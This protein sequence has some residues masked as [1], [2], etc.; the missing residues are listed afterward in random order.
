[1]NRLWPWVMFLRLKFVLNASRDGMIVRNQV[2]GNTI[3]DDM[4]RTPEFLICVHILCESLCNNWKKNQ[5]VCD[6]FPCQGSH[7]WLDVSKKC[8]IILLQL[9]CQGQCS[10]CDKLQVGQNFCFAS[11][12]WNILCIKLL[13][14]SSF[15]C[16]LVNQVQRSKNRLLCLQTF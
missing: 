2:S 12:K 6:T 11:R 13:K 8:S 1:M 14:I 15:Q 10:H 9:Q 3:T 5:V 4:S 16:D 7:I